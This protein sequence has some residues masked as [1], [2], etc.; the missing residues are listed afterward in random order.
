MEKGKIRNDYFFNP[1][2]YAFSWDKT[3]EGPMF[4]NFIEK[5]Y[6]SHPVDVTK[7]I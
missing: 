5:V 2:A 6:V 7:M 1:P 3:K 4:W